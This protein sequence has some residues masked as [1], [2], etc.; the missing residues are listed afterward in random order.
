[1]KMAE[2]PFAKSVHGKEF[3]EKKL[4]AYFGQKELHQP[5]NRNQAND[6]RRASLRQAYIRCPLA[7]G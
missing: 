5:I 3:T 4:F 7:L 2:N 6:A 1:M